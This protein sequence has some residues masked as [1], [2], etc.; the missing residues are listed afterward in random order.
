MVV[1]LATS[2]SAVLR[3]IGMF[4]IVATM[5]MTPMRSAIRAALTI[6]V[7]VPLLI[8]L[9]TLGFMLAAGVWLHEEWTGR[10][11]RLVTRPVIAAP[12]IIA[13]THI[14]GPAILGE[15]TRQ[16]GQPG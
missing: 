11:H 8:R 2:V 13:R 14:A 6:P 12:V 9:T 15:R 4:A 3:T 1:G 16:G 5:P 7:A 10:Q